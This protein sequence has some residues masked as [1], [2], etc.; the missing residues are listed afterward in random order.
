MGAILVSLDIHCEQ[1]TTEFCNCQG[2]R[3]WYLLLLLH[4][5]FLANGEAQLPFQVGKHIR[6][7]LKFI[8]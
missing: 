6:E 8:H 4:K 5:D 3:I 7:T 1:R 2:V